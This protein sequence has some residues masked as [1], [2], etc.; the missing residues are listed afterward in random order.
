MPNKDAVMVRRMRVSFQ[1]AE[2]PRPLIRI[3]LT[4]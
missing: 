3:A 4:I 1:I 2:N